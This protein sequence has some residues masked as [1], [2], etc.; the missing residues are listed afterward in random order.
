MVNNMMV[1]NRWLI[2]VITMMV[3]E[4]MVHDIIVFITVIMV[5]MINGYNYLTNR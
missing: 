2:M 3:K 1:N 5:L 4:A